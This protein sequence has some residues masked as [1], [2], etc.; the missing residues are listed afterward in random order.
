[1]LV[2]VEPSVL[3]I[4]RVV[5]L[6]DTATNR[7]CSADQQTE[8]HTFAAAADWLVQDVPFDEVITRFVPSAETAANRPSS[9]D[10][11][12]PDH[13]F[14][15]AADWSVQDVPFDD[16]MTR[17]VPD[18]ATATSSPR[19]GDQ[20]TDFQLFVG[21]EQSRPVHVDPSADVITPFNPAAPTATNRPSA[22]AQTTEFHPLVA[23]PVCVLHVEPSDEVMA[24]FADAVDTAQNRPR[25]GDQQMSCQSAE[26]LVGSDQLTPSVEVWMRS[27]P[28]ESAHDAHIARSGDQHTPFHW[29]DAA[30]DWTVQ[31]DTNAT[32][33]PTEVGRV[34]VDGDTETGTAGTSP[35]WCPGMTVP[36]R[37][38]LLKIGV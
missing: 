1:M 23:S 12:T 26:P 29:I 27:V 34:T 10:Q 36:C 19:S 24:P 28:P 3:H 16:V 11:V 13:W 14:A 35:I 31:P 9:G 37:G 20:H 21:D 2:H 38:R 4:A 22:S 15:S 18:V 6:D 30:L 33:P 5:P 25:S 7:A 8:F 17:F 32:L